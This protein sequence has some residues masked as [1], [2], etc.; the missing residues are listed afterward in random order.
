LA[1]SSAEVYESHFLPAEE[2]DPLDLTGLISRVL[3]VARELEM[4]V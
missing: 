2:T 1:G 3:I 4:V